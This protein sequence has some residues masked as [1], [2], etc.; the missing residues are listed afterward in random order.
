MLPV[1]SHE[2]KP[3][4]DYRHLPWFRPI[5]RQCLNRSTTLEFRRLILASFH[6]IALEPEHTECLD[7]DLN[8]CKTWY[9]QEILLHRII[10]MST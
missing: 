6:T 1:H 7:G 8:V 3:L 10:F 9:R 4:D 2:A 5:S